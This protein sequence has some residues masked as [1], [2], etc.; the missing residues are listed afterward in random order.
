MNFP[1]FIA[2]R[3]YGSK[4]TEGHNYSRPTI[5]IAMAGIA[6]GLVVMLVSIAVVLGFKREVS[7]KVV[8]FGSHLQVLSLSQDQNYIMYP[9]VTN[10]SLRQVVA[11][12]GRVRHVQEFATI[13]G[14]LKTERDFLGILLKGVGE[15]YDLSFIRNYLIEGE[16]PDF[17]AKTSSNKV[18][19]SN[20]MAKS[21]S[22][23]VGDR[24]FAYFV[25]N[26]NM[27]ARRLE[28]AGIYETHLAEYDKLICLTDIRTVR[29]LNNWQTDESSGLE[30]HVDTEHASSAVDMLSDFDIVDE[31]TRRLGTKVNHTVDWRGASRGVYSIR[32]I[33]PHIFSWLEVLDA[34]V[35][36][37]LILMLAISS[38][39]IVSGLL[40]VML[41]RI[42]M[43][44]LL[45]ALGATNGLI[46]RVF[47]HFSIMMVG[48][49]VLIGDIL[50]M[51]FCYLQHHYRFIRLDAE[52][53]YIDAVPIEWNWLAFVAVN[54]GVVLISA[55]VIFGA[56]YL[57]SIKGPATTLRWE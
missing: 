36:M 22:L 17:S 1:L 45:K 3:I 23:K 48:Q 53:Y 33:A 14:M 51:L 13:S 8:G 54:V 12:T 15:D 39:T 19:I 44:G 32:D 35:V 42:R 37:I 6:I 30:V 10:D 20:R 49:A 31:V 9:L 24:V 25:G 2:R 34:N 28:V 18:V 57:M 56:S 43:I 40:I 26:N 7:G 47:R 46:R 29:K 5:F 38:F 41:E 4:G 55:I 16:V 21:L 11:K 52:N 50:A 27:R